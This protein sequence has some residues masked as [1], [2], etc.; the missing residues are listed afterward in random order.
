MSYDLFFDYVCDMPILPL[1][2]RHV[3]I[4]VTFYQT[5]SDTDDTLEL[6]R[7]WRNAKL[8]IPDCAD[9]NDPEFWKITSPT[10]ATA[11]EP[12]DGSPLDTEELQDWTSP[13][14]AGTN[15]FS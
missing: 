9:F 8:P 4:W 5:H 12:T 14:L 15:A 1:L 2:S 3:Q 11:D 6:I 7:R 13:S 10:K